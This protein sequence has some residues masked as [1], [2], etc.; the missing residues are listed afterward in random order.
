MNYLD[1]HDFSNAPEIEPLRKK[2]GRAITIKANAIAKNAQATS[3]AKTWAIAALADPT[4][5]LPTLL[6]YILAEYNTVTMTAILAAPDSG[7]DS[8]QAAVNAAVDTLLGV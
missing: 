4:A 2:I 3:G 6:N 1:L 7:A 5:Y 8:V